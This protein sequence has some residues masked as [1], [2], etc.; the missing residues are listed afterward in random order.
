MELQLVCSWLFRV[1]MG[2]N[3]V[4]WTACFAVIGWWISSE[5]KWNFFGFLNAHIA[6]KIGH[7]INKTLYFL[8][9]VSPAI[10]IFS[11]CQ[12]HKHEW[13][14]FFLNLFAII[15][16]FIERKGYF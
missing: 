15:S 5:M 16:I 1:C 10:R 12:G 2:E 14:L 11:C 6:L 8:N 4:A 9:I 13:N 7:R 3:V